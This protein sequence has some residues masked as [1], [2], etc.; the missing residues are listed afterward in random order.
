MYEL[1]RNG[2]V[3][4]SKSD[5]TGPSS[6]EKI[7]YRTAVSQSLVNT[8]LKLLL[9]CNFSI[10]NYYQLPHF[11]KIISQTSTQVG[12]HICPLR[13]LNYIL[14]TRPFTKNSKYTKD[15]LLR[16]IN[17]YDPLSAPKVLQLIAVVWNTMPSRFIDAFRG[18]LCLVPLSFLKTSL[19]VSLPNNSGSHT[20]RFEVITWVLLNIGV[21]VDVT[22]C[23]CASI[24]R[25][26]EES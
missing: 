8:G 18:S 26:F 3:F 20:S 6:Y 4:K 12:G 21:L 10:Q 9:L 24:W 22:S 25:P 13:K 14:K 2:K 23:N 17:F 7:I 11:W 5:G 1:K 15:G 16:P 19:K